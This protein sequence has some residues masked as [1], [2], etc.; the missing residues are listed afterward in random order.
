V[1][2]LSVLVFGAAMVRTP[3][4]DACP[5]IFILLIYLLCYY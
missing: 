5:T 4:P 3:D 1:I 2:V